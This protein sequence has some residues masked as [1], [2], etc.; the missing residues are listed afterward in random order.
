MLERVVAFTRVLE[1]VAFPAGG[2]I[3]ELRYRHGARSVLVGDAE[4]GQVRAHRSIEIDET[5]LDEP[6]QR[7]GGKRLRRRAAEEERLLVH[8]QRLLDVRDAMHGMVLLTVMEEPDGDAG[9]LQLLR[10]SRDNFIELL[11]KATLQR[12]ELLTRRSF[13]RTLGEIEMS[14]A[15]V[16]PV[17]PW[18]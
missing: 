7:G 12:P 18:S 16:E 10:K 15:A 17:S 5:P 6:H 14:G 3:Q 4:L 13:L 9:H 8:G 2:V 1:E 11:H